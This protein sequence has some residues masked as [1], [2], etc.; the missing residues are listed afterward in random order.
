MAGISNHASAVAAVSALA[1][2]QEG[3]ITVRQLVACGVSPGQI[4]RWLRDRRLR[5]TFRGVFALG[6]RRPGPHARMRAGVLACP[7]A[8]I[9]HRSAAFLLGFGKVAP[10]VVDL[11]PTEQGGR[12]IDGIKAHR[13]PRPAPSELVLVAGIP[14]TGPAR[15]I[16]AL[17]GTYGEKE[18]RETVERAAGEKLLDLAAIDA[19]LDSGPRRRGAPC[20][21]RVIEDWRPVAET[22]NFTDARSL[23]E[24]KFLPL[25][26]RAGL[27]MPRVNAPVRTVE[28]I[29]EVD[30]LWPDQC[31]VVEADS[32]R[33]HAIEVAF[34]RDHRR[35]RELLEIGYGYLRVTWREAE[36]EPEAVFAAVRGELLRRGAQE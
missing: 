15:T 24:V 33:H 27:P 6:H 30:L 28:S 5:P 16:V 11:I 17:A 35:D 1:G 31:F 36:R 21:R 3:L 29:L 7:D 2:R 18:M 26:A 22:A 14:C 25:I 20:L 19:T 12:K 13:V 32:R 23:F 10:V 8:V 9:S 34:E 4:E